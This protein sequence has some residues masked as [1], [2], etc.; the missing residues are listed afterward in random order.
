MT[1]H[2]QLEAM[3]LMQENYF[4]AYNAIY[5]YHS[6]TLYTIDTFLPLSKL[7]LEINFL[8]FN[9]KKLN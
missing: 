9:I 5:L 6:L 2:N 3:Q 1:E 7:V 4:K 8:N